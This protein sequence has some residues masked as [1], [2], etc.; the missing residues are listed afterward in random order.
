MPDS[1][2]FI[3]AKH[4]VHRKRR[5]TPATPTTTGVLVVSVV[6]LH[7][8]NGYRWTFDTNIESLTTPTPSGYQINGGD[9]GDSDAP[10]GNS[11]NLYFGID[12]PGLPWE[13][14]GTPDGIVF[15][16]GKTIEPGQSGV[17]SG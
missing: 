3:V 15:E 9:P 14:V 10:V 8:G 2:S 6:S 4:R 1:Q 12:D 11:V 17:T 7:N 16:G 13:I 5:G